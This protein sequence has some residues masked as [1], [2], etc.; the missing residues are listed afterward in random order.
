MGQYRRLYGERATSPSVHDRC[1]RN[2]EVPSFLD[3][4]AQLPPL[5]ATLHFCIDPASG[6]INTIYTIFTTIVARAIHPS[7][8]AIIHISTATTTAAP[9]HTNSTHTSLSVTELLHQTDIASLP[10]Q[11]HFHPIP[12]VNT[13]PIAPASSEQWSPIGSTRRV[14]RRPPLSFST[15][16][17]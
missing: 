17:I 10:P 2:H 8:P 16:L 3:N 13:T 5:L 6:A 11:P 15:G 12:A 14:T 1:D 7:T 4:T 9:R